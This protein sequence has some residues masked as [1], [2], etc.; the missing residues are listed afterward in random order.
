M[1]F[2]AVAFNYIYVSLLRLFCSINVCVQDSI[3]YCNINTAAIYE[4]S[5]AFVSDPIFKKQIKEPHIQSYMLHMF[6]LIHLEK[7]IFFSFLC[8][9]PSKKFSLLR[10]THTHTHI[11]THTHTHTHIYIYIYIFSY[12][13]TTNSPSQVS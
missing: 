13:H 4:I 9:V 12:L 7:N 1:S 8:K 6:T 2:S 10:Y 5:P 11:H 3:S